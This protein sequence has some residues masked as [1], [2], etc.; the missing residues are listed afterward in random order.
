MKSRI[1]SRLKI[2]GVRVASEALASTSTQRETTGPEWRLERGLGRLVEISSGA[3]PAGLS[4]AAAWVREAQL[5]GEPVLWIAVG[6]STYFPPDFDAAGV[7]LAA[8]PTARLERVVDAAR[9]A[10][11]ALRSGGLGLLVLD[12]TEQRYLTLA[13]QSRLAGLAQKHH[14]ALAL[15]T[16]KPEDE[17]SVGSLVSLRVSASVSRRGFDQFALQWRALKDKRRGPGWCG[18]EARR[19][20]DGLC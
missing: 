1:T 16:R 13:I 8:L 17:G 19:G 11:T 7:D 2:R 6:A 9:V 18:E 12:L 10:D 3:G 15:L 4:A 5:M 20:V 14:T